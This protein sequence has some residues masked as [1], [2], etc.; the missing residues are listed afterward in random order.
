MLR[1]HTWNTKMFKQGN[2]VLVCRYSFS[3][4]M[5]FLEL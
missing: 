5:T 1:L 3:S 4:S 2:A